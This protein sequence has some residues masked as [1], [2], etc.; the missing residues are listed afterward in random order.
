[1]K[2]NREEAQHILATAKRTINN[3][4]EYA[5]H[6]GVWYPVATLVWVATTGD[7]PKSTP[8]HWNNNPLDNSF[9]NLR[10]PGRAKRVTVQA[11]TPEVPS[12]LFA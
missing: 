1:M 7:W 6:G 8:R 4:R 12:S 5:H 9:A 3:R 11:P 2:L 10:P